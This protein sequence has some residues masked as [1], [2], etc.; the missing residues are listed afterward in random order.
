MK[1]LAHRSAFTLAWTLALWSQLGL[2]AEPVPAPQAS[3]SA[4]AA[5]RFSPKQL[6]EDLRFIQQEIARIH[7]DLGQSADRQQLELAYRRAE[8]ELQRGHLSRDQAWLV[9]SRLNPVF[10]DAHLLV[11]PA[12]RVAQT[13]A[14]LGNGGRLFPFEVQVGADG[15]VHIRSQLGG[16]KSLLS[17][18]RIDKINGQPAS[19][20]AKELLARTPGD[21]AAFRANV[22]SHRWHYFFWQL[23]GAPSE[24]ELQIDQAG[25]HSKLLVE[26]SSARPLLAQDQ[27]FEDVYKFELL[28]NQTALLTIKS[29]YWEDKPRF[30]AFVERAF[31]RIK[32]A[33]VKHLVIDVRDNGGGDDDMWKVPVL[34][35]IADKPFRNGSDY[36]KMVIAGRASGEEK[37]GDIVHGQGDTWVQ[38]E[39][40]HPL[41]FAGQTYVLIGRSTYSSAV[42]FSNVVQ[43]FGFAKLVGSE[44]YV[45]SRTSGGIQIIKLPHTGLTL[46][47]PRFVLSRP[48]GLRTPVLLQPDIV[49]PDS[50]FDDHELVRGLTQHIAASQG[51]A[52]TQR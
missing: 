11:N 4:S 20:I 6:Q 37:V 47:A 17:G 7:P 32:S 44:G 48:S 41:R 12:D 33:Q 27:S 13:K 45:R 42:L 34:R 51:A 19:D 8:A 43:D 38:P 5:A 52:P 25:K 24:Y 9:L 39:P 22:L 28:A 23:Y 35:Y 3:A 49:L 18:A 1:H 50:P 29:F 21:T 10:A 26:G 40:E 46:V 14:H 2:A 31:E 16:A 15:Q 30:A 36:V